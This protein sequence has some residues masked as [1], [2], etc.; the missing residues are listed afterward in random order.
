MRRRSS[1]ALLATLIAAT[2]AAQ[3]VSV[4]STSIAQV[5]KGE[6]PG[7]ETSTYAPFTQFLGIDATKLKYDGLSLHIF[8]WGRA[9]LSDQSRY[10]PDEKKADGELTYGYV[11]YRFAQ[12]NAEVKAG[13]FAAYDTGSAEQV[14]GVSART[15]LANGFTVSGFFGKPVLYK[16]VDPVSQQDYDYQRNVIFGTRLGWRMPK[17]GEIGLSYLMDGSEAPEDLDLP[18][19]ADFTR[20]QVGLDLRI[21]PSPVF[22]LSGRTLWDVAKRAEPAPG[23]EEPS[24]IAEHDYGIAFNLPKSFGLSFNYIQR[25]FFAY[26][27]GTNLPS[28]FRRDEKDK[29]DAFG[30]A[31]TWAASANWF[32]QA[33]Y[34]QTKRET[35]GDTNRYGGEV[36]WNPKD[37]KITTGASAHY[38]EPT[39]VYL[40]DRTSP[41]KS[42]K[43]AEGRAWI[44]YAQGKLSYAFDAIVMRY[45]GSN[46]YTYGAQWVGE[47]V[48]SVGYQVSPNLRVS[49]DLSFGK[50]PVSDKDVRGLIR[51]DYRFGTKK[52]G[53]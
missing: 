35:F 25:N 1:V 11:R 16:T 5:W 46:P 8:G 42:L 44:M 51:C 6:T 34:K 4:T 32:F 15:D 33:D 12:A 41:D 21:A 30:G 38:V 45:S 48:G 47:A 31:I 7:G 10:Y 40:V 19:V 9:D 28:L 20:R 50:T 39:E 37:T 14:D 29:F 22:S 18:S 43:H 27:A 17:V 2:A 36:R 49:G 24:K 52:G 26:F 3:D 53:Q 13:R 23:A